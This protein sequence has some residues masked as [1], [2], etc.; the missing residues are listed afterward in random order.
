[1]S[2]TNKNEGNQGN[3]S[4]F[5]YT[6][7]IFIAAII[8]I[9]FAYFTQAHVE[10]SQPQTSPE[11]GVTEPAPYDPEAPDKTENPSAPQGIAKTAAD[12]SQDNMELLEENRELRSRLDELELS[13]SVYEP[14]VKAYHAKAK[15]D[16]ARAKLLLEDIDYNSLTDEEKTL[17]DAI[18][19]DL[20]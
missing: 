18:A 9:L 4:L 10:R 3:N 8:V 20:Q 16:A 1:M 7:L 17:Y 15:N 12:L 11:A 13:L 19:S 6:A 2:D 14:L 5:L